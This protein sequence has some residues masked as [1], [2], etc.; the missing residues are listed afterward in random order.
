M[1][2]VNASQEKYGELPRCPV[3]CLALG[4]LYEDFGGKLPSRLTDLFLAF[5]KHMTRKNLQ[6]RGEPMCYGVLP[7]RYTRLFQV[8]LPRRAIF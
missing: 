6:R 7:D 1:A 2:L 3:M 8:S 5:L 4:V